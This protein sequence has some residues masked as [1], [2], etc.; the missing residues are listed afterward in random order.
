MVLPEPYEQ[1]FRPGIQLGLNRSFPK[2]LGANGGICDN[3]NLHPSVYH[4]GLKGK[5][6]YFEA[7]QPFSELGV[8]RFFCHSEKYSRLSKSK[9]QL[10]H[11]V[12]YGLSLSLKVLDK[13]SI[14][15]LD[16]DYGINDL[17]ITLECLHHYPKKTKKKT[18]NFCQFGFQVS[19]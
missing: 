16:Q 3:S 2:E 11:Y 5:I 14:Y 15:A 4:F 19:F 7:L 8:A 18:I 17:G 13:L 10:S 12:S 1:V 6:P 9:T